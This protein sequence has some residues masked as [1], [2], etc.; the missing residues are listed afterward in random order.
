MSFSTVGF[1]GLGNIGQPMAENLLT[2]DFA[3]SVFDINP[4][5]VEALQQAGAGIAPTPAAMASQCQMIGL[6]VRDDRDVEQVFNDDNG[7]LEG[8]EP[9]LVVAIHSTV[10]PE[11]V[12]TIAAKAARQNVT[13]IDAPI[14]GGAP[15]ARAKALTYMVGGEQEVV[16]RC[17]PVF[18]TS[19]KKIIHAGALGMGMSLKLCNNSM[20][21]AGFIA[22]Y[23]ASRLA[24]ACGLD[25]AVLRELGQSNGVIT[26]QMEMFMGLIDA[27]QTMD[28]EAYQSLVAGFS[29]VAQKDLSVALEL[30]Q[31]VGES[32]PGCENSLALMDS[33]YRDNY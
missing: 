17:R 16:E 2:G 9:G 26:E 6:C 21:Y 20:T 28:D 22:I 33:V 24:E 3:V 25:I 1:I 19:A 30:A 10:R 27:H 32:L 14:T 23:E 12:H 4:L 8:A 11:T 15:G 7:L 29:A 18:S 5:A 13:V 31:A